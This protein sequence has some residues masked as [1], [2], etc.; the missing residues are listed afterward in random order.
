MDLKNFTIIFSSVSFLFYGISYFTSTK[1]KSE[2]KRFGLEKYGTLTAILEIM[3]GVGLVIGLKFN[4]LLIISAGGLALLMFLGVLVR[5][6]AKDSFG[7]TIP[8]LF[9]MLLNVY[10]LLSVSLS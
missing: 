6:K 7:I 1:M 2:F 10:I 5:I 4:P 9:Y 3:G 8:A